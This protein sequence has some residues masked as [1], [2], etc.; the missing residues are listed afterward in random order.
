MIEVRDTIPGGMARA[1][2][3]VVFPA[4]PD[5]TETVVDVEEFSFELRREVT[6]SNRDDQIVLTIPGEDEE[7]TIRSWFGHLD[8][9]SN[10]NGFQATKVTEQE[11][12]LRIPRPVLM[13]EALPPLD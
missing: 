13:T 11:I 10:V 4:D 8:P 7:M 5:V 3:E 9:D 6:S 1:M 12:V 2:K